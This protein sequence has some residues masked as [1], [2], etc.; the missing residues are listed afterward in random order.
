VG[1]HAGLTPLQPGRTPKIAARV[2]VCQ[3]A[4]D[5]I[6]TLEQ[7]NAFETE[8][9]AAGAD[10]RMLVLGGVAHSFTNPEID[11]LAMPGFT[12]DERADRRTWAVMRDFLDEAL[13][14]VAG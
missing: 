14:P 2:L 4:D 1:F 9:T 10:W 13:G 12:Y 6:I 3:G 7:R 5:P 11:A 8:M